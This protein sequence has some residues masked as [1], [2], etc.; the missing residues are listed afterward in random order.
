M[1]VKRYS[2]FPGNSNSSAIKV[3]AL[4]VSVSSVLRDFNLKRK[5]AS[6]FYQLKSLRMKSVT[7]KFPH[8]LLILF[9][10]GAIVLSVRN[11]QKPSLS[12]DGRV[13]IAGP[14]ATVVLN[15]EF[16]F[17]LKDQ[18]G[19]EVTKIKYTIEQAELRNEIIVKGKRAI[20]VQGRTFLVFNLK[21][22]NDYNQPIEM[23]V[24][25]FI[26][27]SINGNKTELLAPEI[28]NDPVTIQAIS[29]K[30]TRLGFPIYDTDKNIAL[31]VG[32]I[33]AVKEELPLSF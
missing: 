5:A 19:I 2:S 11:L 30:Y 31:L 14:K 23:N 6:F 17:P 13:I 26:R 9:V 21:I 3:P 27:L 12:Q 8:A 16:L 7:R 22:V 18:K 24:R 33:S 1:R 29:T 28:H 10:I 32:E 4:F 25:D 15:K 20:A